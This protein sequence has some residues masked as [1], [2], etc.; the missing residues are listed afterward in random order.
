MVHD[1]VIEASWWSYSLWQEL[2]TLPRTTTCTTFSISLSP[3]TYIACNTRN[4]QTFYVKARKLRYP[5]N[6]TSNHRNTLIDLITSQNVGKLTSETTFGYSKVVCYVQNS[7]NP[8]TSPFFHY[9]GVNSFIKTVPKQLTTP[10]WISVRLPAPCVTL[11]LKCQLDWIG[12][13][14]SDYKS[15]AWQC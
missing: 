9:M 12:W 11:K 8:L 1:L 5:G 10:T 7:E 15:T 13:D 2:F 14:I 6:G 3:T 4:K